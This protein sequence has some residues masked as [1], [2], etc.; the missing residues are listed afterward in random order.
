MQLTSLSALE[1]RE[2]LLRKDFSA[3][4]LTL[5]HLERIKKTNEDLNSFIS[6][7][8][9]K[10]L[11]HAEE[12]DAVLK[13][14]KEKSPT[15]TGIP[16]ALKDNFVCKGSETTCASKILRGFISPYNATV[17]KKLK[18]QGAV[19]LGKTNMDEFAMGSSGENSSFGPTK[20]P[21]DTTRVPGGSSSGSAVAVCSGQAAI[22]F[23]SDTGGSI[24]QPAALSG[25]LGLKPTYGR[26]SRY[27][28]VAFASSLDQIGPFART[29]K[30]LAIALE[31]VS[32]YDLH[33]STSVNLEV[34][35]YLSYLKQQEGRGLKGLRVGIPKE[36]FIEGIQKETKE[37]VEAALKTLEK[38]GAE[39][40][41]IS[42]PHT[43]HALDTYYIL[44]P[45]EASSN[46]SRYDGVRYGHRTERA[47]DLNEMYA[48]T[49]AEGFGSEVI[50]RILVGTYVLSAG[51]YDAYYKKAQQVRRLIKNDFDFAFANQ[52]DIIATPVSPC[53]AFKIGEK[54]S[55]PLEM[56]LADVF[57]LPINL[58]GIPG[59]SIPC[60]L[61]SKTL[62]IGLQLLAPAF[63]EAE[64]LRVSDAFLEES[65]F[66]T[67]EKT[68]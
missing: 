4:E 28:L 48:R 41:Q 11:Q 19:I 54:T 56:Y 49:R 23:G 60:G 30:D 21:W 13:Q 38:L 47:K 6:I 40:V 51:Y 14:E 9:D 58:A 17:V 27:G 26:V 8:E 1:M 22:S 55:S 20:N 15:L 39:L 37:S 25:I 35:N 42:L 57:T 45:A 10:A 43:K 59:I 33:D 16:I 68:V 18:K 12:A 36:Y 5:A 62:P 46:L 34:P 31:A 53:T 44:A 66:N 24:R 67:K 29:A 50:R 3:K 61:D 64:L 7:L 2:G 63:K 65:K 52:C 32:G